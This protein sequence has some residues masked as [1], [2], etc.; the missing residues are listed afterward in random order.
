MIY[1]DMMGLRKVSGCLVL[2][3]FSCYMLLLA[4][5]GR[6]YLVGHA[7]ERNVKGAG[8]LPTLSESPHSSDE[9]PDASVWVD[10]GVNFSLLISTFLCYDLVVMNVL[11]VSLATD[12]FFHRTPFIR[13]L[14]CAMVGVLT[15]AAWFEVPA[16]RQELWQLNWTY[17]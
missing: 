17:L 9:E 13:L 6:R 8:Q 1:P 7:A 16:L 2:A 15:A 3:V 12:N 10:L 14:L 4:E 11:V 5:R